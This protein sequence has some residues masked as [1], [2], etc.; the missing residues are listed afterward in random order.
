M[1][2]KYD[3]HAIVAACFMIQAVGVGTM[4]TY[5]VF[6]NFLAD[7]FGWS[8]AII[9][10]ASSLAFF[11][12]GWGAI[13]LGRLNDIYGPRNLMRIAAIFLGSGVALT[14]RVAEIWQLYFFYGLIFGIGLG[15]I[16]VIALTTTARWFSHSRGLMTGIVKVGT[17]TGQF[18]VPFVASLLISAYGWRQAYLTIGMGALVI[19][20]AVAQVLKRDPASRPSAGPSDQDPQSQ[21]RAFPDHSIGA[22]AAVHTVQ[23]WIICGA[24]GLL[25]FCL[26]IVLVHIVPH[27]RDQGL[28]PPLAAGVLST[29]GAV[30][31]LGRLFAGFSIDRVGSKPIMVACFFVLI[32]GLL[33][34]PLADSLWTLYLFAAV[35][36]LAHGGVFTAISPL[37]AE[38][39]GIA[40]HG[41]IFG[42]VVFFGTTGGS[43]G[44]I[45]AG[46]LFDITGSYTIT[47]RM[48]TLIS[49]IGLAL[50]LFLKPIRAINTSV[51][52]AEFEG[53][54]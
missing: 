14:A 18:L 16:D 40:S 20:L 41:A 53:T 6:F 7:D 15:A 48:I 23:F 11:L 35:Y 17:G 32:G 31:I 51:Q 25:V 9:S 2:Y 46:Q 4:V 36:G 24:Y 43:I 13:V 44:P 30:S 50:I 54:S 21:P 19:L 34:L 3:N 45:V 22:R 5:G 39:F 33:W 37:I 29:I 42:I 12:S 47:F 49:M 1:T 26:L 8:R 38:V 28:T 52:L 10:G 27:A